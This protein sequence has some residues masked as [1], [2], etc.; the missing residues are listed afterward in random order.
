MSDQIKF[1]LDESVNPAVAEGLLRRGVKV[2]TSH[3]LGMLGASDSEH[4]VKAFTEQRVIF[5]QDD[6]F[7]KLHASGAEHAGIVY[8][9]QQTSVGHI[10]RGLMLIY[11]VLTPDEMKGHVEFL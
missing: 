7:L 5:T 6:D 11:Q 1:H 3:D 2:T 8:A 4:L 9:R 10:I